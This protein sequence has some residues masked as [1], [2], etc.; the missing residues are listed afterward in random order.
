[1][2][3]DDLTAQQKEDVCII[4]SEG[5]YRPKMFIVVVKYI[6]YVAI[7]LLGVIYYSDIA[8]NTKK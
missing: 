7:A 8:S 2:K 1:L 5:Y 3:N 6:L 4:I